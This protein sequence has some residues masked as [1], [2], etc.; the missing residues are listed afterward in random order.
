MRSPDGGLHHATVRT[1]EKVTDIVIARATF[2]G[3]DH[4]LHHGLDH[5]PESVVIM[6]GKQA[7]GGEG[8]GIGIGLSQALPLQGLRVAL[9]L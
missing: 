5:G 6:G 4:G 8:E 7:D 3:P 1:A 2:H 9:P